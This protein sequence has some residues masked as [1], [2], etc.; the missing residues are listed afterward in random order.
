MG[1][2]SVQDLEDSQ[3]LKLPNRHTWLRRLPRACKTAP[4]SPFL[5]STPQ[6][7]TQHRSEV[8]RRGG[9]LPGHTPDRAPSFLHGVFS[10]CA[11]KD[12]CSVPGSRPRHPQ[13]SWIKGPFH[14]VANSFCLLSL[15]P[16]RDR[17]ASSQNQPGNSLPRA[18]GEL[19]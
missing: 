16:H 15:P 19:V 13:L 18:A 14:A 6:T 17:I 5:P 4:L 12:C 7:L 3:A 1:C 10:A 8:R 2:W 11:F 9:Q